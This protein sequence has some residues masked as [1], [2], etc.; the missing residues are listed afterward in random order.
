M[1]SQNKSLQLIVISCFVIFTLICLVVS[2]S[3]ASKKTSQA[4]EITFESEQVDSENT[5]SQSI[6][7]R[8]NNPLSLNAIIQE[9]S[10]KSKIKYD[11]RF[12]MEKDPANFRY[13]M[14]LLFAFCAFGLFKSFQEYNASQTVE[15]KTELEQLLLAKEEAPDA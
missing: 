9:T 8:S 11:N 15:G 5:L 13:L 4:N 12:V 1:K 14:G 6:N 3:K 7:L 10:E 2:L